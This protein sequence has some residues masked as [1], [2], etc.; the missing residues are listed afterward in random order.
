M[1]CTYRVCLV[2]SFEGKLWFLTTL[3]LQNYIVLNHGI[4]MPHWITHKYMKMEIWYPLYIRGIFQAYTAALHIHGVYMVYTTIYLAW[5][6]DDCR[7]TELEIKW[8]SG[9]H[10]PEVPNWFDCTP[11]PWR[12]LRLWNHH[13]VWGSSYLVLWYHWF[14]T[15]ATVFRLPQQLSWCWPSWPG[16]SAWGWGA[17]GAVSTWSGVLRKV[18][19]P[20]FSSLNF[21]WNL[22]SCDITVL[23]MISQFGLWY[24]L[25][26][27]KC[28]ITGVI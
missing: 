24:H 11:P 28:D 7:V 9:S 6:P 8:N 2:H 22:G 4:G 12:R 21:I 3:L 23:V 17:R 15:H 1:S 27:H 10:Q 18:T 14:Q 13:D 25:W 5:V 26:Y 19:V 20:V 16:P